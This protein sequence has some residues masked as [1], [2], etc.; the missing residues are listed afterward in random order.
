MPTIVK[1]TAP[2]VSSQLIRKRRE[3]RQ[4]SQGEMAQL[5]GVSRRTIVRWEQ[6]ESVPMRVFQKLL[7]EL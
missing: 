2:A 6:G 7:R 4:L 3:Q 1:P 5:L